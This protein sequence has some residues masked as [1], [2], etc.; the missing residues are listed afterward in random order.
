M[1]PE[2]WKIRLSH[3]S[4]TMFDECQRR[5][6]YRYACDHF[7]APMKWALK[8]QAKLSAWETTAG[9]VVDLT[10]SHA[11]RKYKERGAWPENLPELGLK[12][13]ECLERYSRWWV[14]QVG[15]GMRWPH[16]DYYGPI[17]RHYYGQEITEQERQKC[18]DK[19]VACLSAFRDAGPADTAVEL[20]VEH[21]DGPRAPSEYAPT[22]TVRGVDVWAS[23]DFAIRTP[24]ITYIVDWKTGRFTEHSHQRA[25][26]QLHWYAL[27]ADIEWRVPVEQIRVVPVWLSDDASWQPAAVCARSLEELA[28][29]IRERHDL[30]ISKVRLTPEDHVSEEG[31]LPA[32]SSAYCR[33]C[34]FRGAC[35][36]KDSVPGAEKEDDYGW[37]EDA[38]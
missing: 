10:V 16:N 7:P 14:E 38:E 27:Y 12:V 1:A 30:L 33:R 31:W 18:R 19:I 9:K 35:T 26:D 21:W 11:L 3:Y 36:A 8:K 17:D 29:R 22:F 20:G 23:Y 25:L 4:Y 37:P 24:E 34:Q 6:L 13:L 2:S 32:K 28:E 15:A 5:W